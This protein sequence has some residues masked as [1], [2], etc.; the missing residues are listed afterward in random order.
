[1]FLDWLLFLVM[2]LRFLR[3]FWGFLAGSVDKESTFNVGDL[4][5]T[6]GLG[7][8]PWKKVWQPS[9]KFLPGESPW[10]EESGRLQSMGFQIAVPIASFFLFLNGIPGLDVPKS[11]YPFTT[12]GHFVDAEILLR[13]WDKPDLIMVHDLFNVLLDTDC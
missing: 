3:I 13:V 8:F 2:Y 5:S 12:E 7:R 1:M 4:G 9:P 10:T 11:L 6:P